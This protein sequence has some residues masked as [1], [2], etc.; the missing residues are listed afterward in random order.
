MTTPSLRRVDTGS[1]QGFDVWT[2]RTD[3]GPR[4]VVLGGVHGDETEGAVAAGLLTTLSVVLVHGT[5]EIVPVCHEAAFAADSRTSPTDGGNL[6]RVFPGDPGGTDTP[7]LAHH[8]FTEVL[9]GCDL[10]IDLH[11]SGRSYDMPFL[12]GFRGESAGSE[13]LSRQAA[14]AFGGDFLWRHP[15]RSEG[16]TVS[17]V[18]DAIYAESPGG[19]PMN[20]DMANRYVAGVLRVLASMGMVDDAPPP[21]G[22][23]PIRVTGG[24]NLDRDM[25]AVTN[26]GLFL[27][28]VGPGESVHEGQQLGTVID[29]SGTQLEDIVAPQ[30]GYVMALKARSPVVAGDLVINLAKAD[31]V[32]DR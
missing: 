22:G 10:L 7:R 31:V 14:E 12:V 19:G 24:G 26:A 20:I 16:R 29:R 3:S 1:G 5:L 15:G 13:S 27:R 11:T 21:S 6:A 9:E 30:A 17:V 18:D 28:S 2:R 32:A 4:V 23:E 25:I 8:L